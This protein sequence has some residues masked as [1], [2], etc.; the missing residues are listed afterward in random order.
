[1]ETKSADVSTNSDIVG[2]GSIS[3][4]VSSTT[5]CSSSSGSPW[6]AKFMAIAAI[7]HNGCNYPPCAKS[8]E[9]FYGKFRGICEEI[10]LSEPITANV[11]AM[12]Q[13]HEPM[14]VAHFLSVLPSLFN[15]ARS[16]ILGAKELPSLSK[17]LH[18]RLDAHQAFVSE[19]E[20]NSISA[21]EYQHLLVAQFYSAYYYS[22]SNRCFHYLCCYSYSLVID[23]SASNHLT[24]TSLVLSGVSK[25]SSLC[26]SCRRIHLTI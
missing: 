10:D 17:D 24:G 20:M 26:H 22:N 13:Q 12:K 25:S 23:S 5:G 11:V 6:W 14:R 15:G 2:S 8:V 18:G 19:D 9:D 16:Q 21:K 4:T 3:G 7:R 1:M